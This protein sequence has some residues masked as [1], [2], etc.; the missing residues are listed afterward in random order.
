MM[1]FA[2]RGATVARQI[3][4]AMQLDVGPGTTLWDSKH[5]EQGETH[6]TASLLNKERKG[7]ERMNVL[8][9]VQRME[10]SLHRRGILAE[11]LAA[12][13]YQQHTSALLIQVGTV[14]QRVHHDA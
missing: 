6:L 5:K 3:Y 13:V 7:T 12:K 8:S 1:L 4:D 9:L 11:A 14:T 10:K 2:N